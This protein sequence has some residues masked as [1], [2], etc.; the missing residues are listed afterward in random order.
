MR[1]Y[2]ILV[3]FFTYQLPHLRWDSS[4]YS[5]RYIHTDTEIY[6]K[7]QTNCADFATG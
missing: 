1:P 3:I 2:N 5:D 6:D 7:T 4:G